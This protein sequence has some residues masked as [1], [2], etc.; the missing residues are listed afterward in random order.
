MQEPDLKVM[1]HSSTLSE[2]HKNLEVI[3]SN[4][5]RKSQI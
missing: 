3:G 1:T 4:E 5:H 2:K